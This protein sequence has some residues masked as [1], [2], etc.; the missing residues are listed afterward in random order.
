MS[1]SFK[2]EGSSSGISSFSPTLT[3]EKQ[4]V[5]NLPAS[6]NSVKASYHPMGRRKWKDQG[7]ILLIVAVDTQRRASPRA[8]RAQRLLPD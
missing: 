4:E 2:L 6:L 8:R 1:H 3:A 7:L 5:T